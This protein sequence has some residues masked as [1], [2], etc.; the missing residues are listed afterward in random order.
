MLFENVPYNGFRKWRGL[1]DRVQ[2][3]KSSVTQ[4]RP[5]GSTLPAELL[6]SGIGGDNPLAI[7]E[8]GIVH[9]GGFVGTAY[10]D[11]SSRR[12]TT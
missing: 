5:F 8:M 7:A 4:H 10:L 11:G 3:G 2:L 6:R 1:R 9:E 12:P